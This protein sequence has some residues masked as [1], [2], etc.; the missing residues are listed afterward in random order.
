MLNCT[1]PAGTTDADSSPQASTMTEPRTM[2]LQCAGTQPVDIPP[3]V[4]SAHCGDERACSLTPQSVV[5]LS[6]YLGQTAS[7]FAMRRLEDNPFVTVLLPLGYMDDLLMHGLLAFSGAHLAMKE[8]ENA[9]LVRT[10]SMHY[11]KMITGLLGEFAALRDDDL[12]KTE[13]LLRILLVACHYEAVSGD[14]KGAMFNHLRAS[15]Q[16]ILSLLAHKNV[17]QSWNGVNVSAL[18]FSIELYSYLVILNTIIPYGK[19]KDRTSALDAFIVSVEDM[20]SFPTFGALFAGSHELFRLIAEV[21]MLASKRLAEEAAGETQPST[22]S[23][24]THDD[25]LQRVQAWKMPPRDAKESV[26]DWEHKRCAAEMFR[27]GLHVYLFAALAGSVITDPDVVCAIHAHV[28]K[29]FTHA[30][31]LTAA[32]NYVATMIWPVLMGGTCLVEQGQQQVLAE[33]IRTGWSSMNHMKVVGDI[34]QLLWKDPDPRAFG[35]YGLYLT[36]EKHGLMVSIA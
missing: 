17:R 30:G 34:L 6:H 29:L 32:N 19:A 24:S 35:P 23:R 2:M 7:Y 10:T 13:R 20:S 12:D 28:V 18:G 27:Q 31:E 9:A 5:L 8:P 21:N 1:W 11:S 33:A 3:A 16:L 26:K 14:T 22:S 36:M 4:P 25:I 15:R